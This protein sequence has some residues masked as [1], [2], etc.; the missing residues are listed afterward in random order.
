MA[1]IFH[2]AEAPQWA[3]AHQ[4]GQYEADSLAEVGFIHGATTSQLPKVA[5]TF[6]A[7][8]DDLLL[9][10]I[11]SERLTSQ[12]RWEAPVHPQTIEDV[13]HLDQEVFP[14][15]YG[16]VNLGAVVSVR[17]LQWQQERFDIW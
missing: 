14:H 9:L 8:R 5:H 12:I 4:Q 1:I 16:A 7:G 17:P 10:E 13:N 11:D 2:I 6:Y 15:I 3:L